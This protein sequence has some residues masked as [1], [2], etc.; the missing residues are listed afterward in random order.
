MLHLVMHMVDALPDG[1]NF[2]EAVPDIPDNEGDEE[3]DDSM[4]SSDSSNS[5]E[6]DD[7]N[8]HEA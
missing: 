2:A 4:S 7:D 8:S 6:D 5:D 3:F 1:L